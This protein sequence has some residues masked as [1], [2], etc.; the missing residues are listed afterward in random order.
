MND[1]HRMIERYKK[2]QA[3]KN[4]H[5]NEI[6]LTA[7]GKAIGNLINAL[8]ETVTIAFKAIKN[9]ITELQTMPEDEF[10]KKLEEL[11]PKLTDE[12]IKALYKIRGDENNGKP[13]SKA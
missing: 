11:R 2:K 4:R 7:L 8:N 13:N 12:Q 6:P 3:A 1:R 9:S 10:Q 5:I